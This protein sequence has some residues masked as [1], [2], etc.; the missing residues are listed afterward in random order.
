MSEIVI[1]GR[2]ATRT[3]ECSPATRVTRSLLGYGLVAGPFYVLVVLA[4]AFLRPGFDLAHDDASLLSNGSWGWVQIGNFVLTGAMVIAFAAGV[5][6]ALGEGRG[7]RWA[8]RLLA[9]YGLGLIAAGVFVADPMNGFPAGAP[10]G[11]PEAMTLH[12]TLHIAF[13]ALGFLGLVVGCF[14]IAARYAAEGRGRWAWFSRLTGV[15]FLLGFVG[16]ASGSGSAAVV[17]GF[18]IALVVAW[19]WLAAL[20]LRLYRSA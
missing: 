16:V 3:A 1:D 19:A 15:L 6:R 9:L 5:R 17:L 14:A 7:A 8:P 13:A 20:S 2:A 12:G 18:W 11:R 4:Q 10:A